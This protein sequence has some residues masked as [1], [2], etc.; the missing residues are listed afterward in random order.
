MGLTQPLLPPKRR[1]QRNPGRK[2]L[3][4]Q[5]VTTG[6][7]FLL[8]SGIPWPQEMGCGS[9]M[10][11]WRRLRDWQEAGVWHKLHELL[12]SNCASPT[13]LIGPEVWWI[14]GPFE[15]LAVGSQRGQPR[16][17]PDQ[18]QGDRADGSEPRQRGL[19]SLGIESVLQQ[20]LTAHG[21]GLASILPDEEKS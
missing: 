16:R 3:S 9:R 19:R 6:M 17:E 12:L 11:C 5:R 13:R 1:R 18:V 15:R 21:S 2:S 20:R 14:V 10:T 4:V 7:L 8:N